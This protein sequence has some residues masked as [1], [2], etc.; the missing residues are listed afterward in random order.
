MKFKQLIKLLIIIV[1]IFLVSFTTNEYKSTAQA[2]SSFKKILTKVPD[3]ERTKF[4]ESLVF[5]K[6]RL[7][8]ARLKDLKEV[9]S[10]SEFAALKR[11]IGWGNST[12]IENARCSGLGEC[13]DADGYWCS[14]S[15]CKGVTPGVSLGEMLSSVPQDERKKILDSI[16]FQNGRMTGV[17]LK[18]INKYVSKDN[19]GQLP[20][21][22]PL[23]MKECARL[24]LAIDEDISCPFTITRFKS[25]A[26]IRGRYKCKSMCINESTD[27]LDDL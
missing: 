8:S 16:D 23:T 4:L 24:G 14:P 22:I 17:N 3:K 11:S 9:L 19:L 27:P 6:G 1:F 13:K 26:T 7:V 12:V 21:P 18:D 10:K 2:T 5:A 15:D 20:L 25:G